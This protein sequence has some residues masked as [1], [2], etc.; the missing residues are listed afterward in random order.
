MRRSLALALLFSACESVAASAAHLAGL[1]FLGSYRIYPPLSSASAVSD[2]GSVVVGVS[3]SVLGSLEAFEWSE[4]R[5]LVGLGVIVAPSASAGVSFATAISAD[6]SEVAGWASDWSIPLLWTRVAGAL[7]LTAPPSF[8]FGGVFYG[9]SDD[10]STA[11]GATVSRVAGPPPFPPTEVTEAM[12]W[13][14]AD[15]VESLPHLEPGDQGSFAYGASA[16]G[17]VVVGFD[18]TPNGRQPVL[19]NQGGVQLLGNL[20]GAT[21]GAA[22]DV[23]ADGTVVVGNSD[24]DQG[25]EAFRWTEAE[26][27]KGL[28]FLSG[29]SRSGASAVTAD[30]LTVVGSSEGFIGSG[31]AFIWDAVHG[32]RD[33]RDVLVN[34]YGLDLTGWSLDSASDISGDGLA[35]VGAGTDPQGYAEAWIATLPEPRAGANAIALVLALVGLR[36]LA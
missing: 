10:G 25:G 22:N 4:A 12:R 20:P 5:G 11:V 3:T 19:W 6:G 13:T 14:N 26:G 34:E 17:A 18:T 30:G 15:G 2:G 31:G 9:L 8:G 16:D 21:S 32:M 36:R 1:G 23:S 33:L 35:I 24:S 29:R 27:M 28:G 7:S